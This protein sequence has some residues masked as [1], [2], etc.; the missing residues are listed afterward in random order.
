[1]AQCHLKENEEESLE[2]S[3]KF[4]LRNKDFRNIVAAGS[5]DDIDSLVVRLQSGQNSCARSPLTAH[6][7]DLFPD[8]WG[9]SP[10]M[11]PEDSMLLQEQEEV[12]VEDVYFDLSD[13]ADSDISIAPSLNDNT[14]DLVEPPPLTNNTPDAIRADTAVNDAAAPASD[15]PPP[16]N[17]HN[18]PS[19]TNANEKHLDNESSEERSGPQEVQPNVPSAGPSLPL[20]SSPIPSTVDSLPPG[21]PKSELVTSTGSK[22]PGGG[23]PPNLNGGDNTIVG[24][25][26]RT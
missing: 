2:G 4:V 11:L 8:P 22:S 25:G 14:A 1:M 19:A 7:R 9:R 18:D 15:P 21:P 26:E 10:R 13:D 20:P 5:E 6:I 17:S 12:D 23:G 3:R 16:S 24:E